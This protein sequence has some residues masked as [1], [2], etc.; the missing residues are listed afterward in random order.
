MDV[1][2]C[3]GCIFASDELRFSAVVFP[4]VAS[5]GGITA[6]EKQVL[7]SVFGVEHGYCGVFLCLAA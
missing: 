2:A 6:N 5:G 4:I 1:T 7:S 3:F